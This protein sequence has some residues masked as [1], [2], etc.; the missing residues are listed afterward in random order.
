MKTSL[1]NMLLLPATIESVSTRQDLTIKVVIGTQETTPQMAADLVMLNRKFVY[2]AVKET[3]FEANETEVMEGLET[4]FVDDKKRTASQR[5]RGVLYRVWQQENKGY[6]D[7]R[8]F[9]L[10]EMERII[11]HFKRKLD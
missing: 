9:Y 10:H 5:L 7:F 1:S 2:L 3:A 6:E 8:L 11:E 4:E